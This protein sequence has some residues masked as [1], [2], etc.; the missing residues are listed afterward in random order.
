MPK[1]ESERYFVT[2]EDLWEGYSP[3][4]GKFS[5][6]LGVDRFGKIVVVHFSDSDSPHLLI[7]GTTGSGKSEALHTLLCGMCHYYTSE[8]IEMLLID[9]KGTEMEMYQ[10]TD[11]VNEEI[12]MYED[13]AL[14]LVDKAVEEMQARFEA[15]KQMTRQ[16]GFRIPDLEKYNEMAEVKLP[17]LVLVIDEYADITSEKSFKK[18][19]EDKV[20]RVAQKGRSAGVHLIIATQKPSAE[21]ISTSLRSNLPAQIALRVKGVNESRV[22]I[23]ESGAEGLIGKGDSIFKSQTSS[24]RVQCGKVRDIGS[25]IKKT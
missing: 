23:E 19:F 22:I 16:K 12:A 15:F 3:E 11:Y 24:R 5:L 13:D 8:Q 25:H 2:T 9:P 17:W 4:L 14:H 21:V 6:P 1:K 7:G 10:D 20:K 18:G